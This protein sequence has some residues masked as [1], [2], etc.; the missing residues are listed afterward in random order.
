MID[1][2]YSS[3]GTI[4]PAYPWLMDKLDVSQTVNKISAMRTIGVPYPEGYESQALD[5]LN[6][7][8]EE[9]YQAIITQD[10]EIKNARPDM[11]LIALIAYL[12]RLGS[13]IHK[14]EKPEVEETVVPAQTIVEPVDS[15]AVTT[16]ADT[17]NT[18]H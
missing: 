11:E 13:D 1:P 5:D 14:G 8:A 10:P 16:T 3:P 6:K 12:E 15:V 4:M 18:S 17:T 7:Q 9:I 2:R